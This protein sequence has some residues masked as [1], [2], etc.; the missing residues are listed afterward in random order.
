MRGYNTYERRLFVREF[1]LVDK[2]VKAAKGVCDASASCCCDHVFEQELEVV[3]ELIS[4][5]G[6][7]DI[8]Q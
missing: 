4:S 6:M 7:Q 8:F 3:K 1:K 5:F 2:K